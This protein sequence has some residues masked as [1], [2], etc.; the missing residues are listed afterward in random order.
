[1]GLVTGRFAPS[2]TGPLHFGSVVTA[3]ASW[4]SARAQGGRWI[5]RIDDLDPPRE[6]AGAAAAIIHTVRALG[7]DWDGDVVFQSRRGAA[8]RSAVAALAAA[9]Q[10]FPCA[11]TRAMTGARPYPGTC[12][13][14]IPPGRRTRALRVRV[15]GVPVT[16]DDAIQ[17]TVVQDLQASCGD[18]V[19]QRA[20]GY[21]AYHLAVAVD[22]AWSGVN[23]VVRGVDLIDSTPRQIH[24]QR[25]LGLPTPRY[26]HIPVVL[27]ADG[28]KL[29]KQTHAAPV[30]PAGAP[31]AL[32]GALDFL[33]LA[34]P[35]NL[36]AQPVTEL[37]D[38]ALPRWSLAAAG[39]ESRRY[40]PTA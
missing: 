18:F 4:L 36:A 38:W 29:S 35:A 24:L 7:L 8:Y 6:M 2:P 17:G 10:V 39:V 32:F 15:D 30:L 27:G 14:G 21:I 23:E 37:L 20:D 33:G 25:L 34:P 3:V 31:A 26:A 12:R 40:L 16:F 5:L 9:R 13:A 28:A 1:M 22:D 19:V 11:C